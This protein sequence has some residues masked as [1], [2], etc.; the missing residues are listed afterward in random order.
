MATQNQSRRVALGAGFSSRIKALYGVS[1][2]QMAI[3]SLTT[4]ALSNIL[5]FHFHVSTLY[6]GLYSALYAVSFILCPLFLKK[7]LSEKRII[8]SLLFS[9]AL[10][11]ASLTICLV[12]LTPFTAMVFTVAEGMYMGIFWVNVDSLIGK[13]QGSISR[14]DIKAKLFRHYTLSWNLGALIG[15]LFGFFLSFLTQSD[16][17]I[18][19]LSVILVLG[20]F[21]CIFVLL[22]RKKTDSITTGL[23]AK[24]KRIK[25][26]SIKFPVGIAYL[27][28]FLFI[29]TKEIYGFSLPFVIYEA[30]ANTYWL[31]LNS[32]LQQVALFIAVFW[33]S[34]QDFN[35]KYKNSL[36]SLGLMLLISL[37]VI[38]RSWVVLFIGFILVGLLS[39]VTYEFTTQLIFRHTA[40]KNST[41]YTT[42]Y[43][44][45]SAIGVFI[46]PLIAGTVATHNMA[47]NFWLVAIL[48]ITGLITLSVSHISSKGFELLAHIHSD[49]VL[50][51]PPIELH[52]DNFFNMAISHVSC[53]K[54][55][56]NII[57]YAKHRQIRS[58]QSE[59]LPLM[60]CQLKI[61]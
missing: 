48:L 42:L 40:E 1:F 24:A 37:L 17:L 34:K 33:A 47:L 29:F 16:F 55:V 36:L 14:S 31:Y 49:N 4:V 27:I 28:G 12:I 25:N 58:L 20:Q 44:S 19:W 53:L 35:G 26:R 23:K 60:N 2:L 56:P 13:I 18:L 43:Q 46:S 7:T 30:Q 32:F 15:S 52:W 8:L 41:K 59:F 50:E 39:G 11:L 22:D 51:A 9:V 21:P 5:I 45:I 3:G 61:G 10:A 6:Y 54:T 57:R 38:E